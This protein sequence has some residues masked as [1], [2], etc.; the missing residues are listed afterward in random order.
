[1]SQF[2]GAR[3]DR[4]R[5]M[6]SGIQAGCCCRVSVSGVVDADVELV[7][8]TVR[9]FGDA[10]KWLNDVPGAV[11]STELLVQTWPDLGETWLEDRLASKLS[12]S[13][14]P[15]TLQTLIT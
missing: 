7:W 5:I 15:Q 11:C 14:E 13:T 1:V 10:K 3:A 9:A 4:E 2:V 6:P 8:S 12:Y